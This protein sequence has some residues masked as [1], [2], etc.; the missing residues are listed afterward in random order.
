MMMS[1]REGFGEVRIEGYRGR[2]IGVESIMWSY[3][4]VSQCKLHQEARQL[5]LKKISFLSLSV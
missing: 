3:R 4:S 2:R 1:K 5:L